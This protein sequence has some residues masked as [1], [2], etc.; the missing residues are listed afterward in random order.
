MMDDFVTTPIT[1]ENAID[2]FEILEAREETGATLIA[3]QLEP[4][5]WYLRIEGE[6]MADSILGHTGSTARL[7]AT[8]K[9]GLCSRLG[10]EHSFHQN[11]NGI[12]IPCLREPRS[13]LDLGPHLRHLETPI[14]IKSS[15]SLSRSRQSVR[16][17]PS[18]VIYANLQQTVD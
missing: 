1:T 3:S 18:P 11:E 14:G 5:E 4:N 13:V 12:A 9:R 2:L 10:L 17:I 8:V 7:P 6:I 15:Y 16:I